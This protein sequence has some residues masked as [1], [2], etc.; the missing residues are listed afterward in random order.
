MYITHHQGSSGKYLTAEICRHPNIYED[1][2]TPIDRLTRRFR[3]RIVFPG[4]DY[5]CRILLR[6]AVHTSTAVLRYHTYGKLKSLGVHPSN[7]ATTTAA[8]LLYRMVLQ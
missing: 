1:F 2:V 8:V 6:T 7:S 3:S 4:Y 5:Y